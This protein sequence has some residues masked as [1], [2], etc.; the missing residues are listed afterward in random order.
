[1]RPVLLS[2]FLRQLNGLYERDGDMKIYVGSGIDVGLK[3]PTNVFRDVFCPD[4]GTSYCEVTVE[5]APDEY[6]EDNS[7]C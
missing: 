5:D 3:R 2:E 7:C 6:F 1:V 4:C